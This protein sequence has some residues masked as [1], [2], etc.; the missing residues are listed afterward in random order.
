MGRMGNDDLRFRQFRDEPAYDECLRL[1]L[2]RGLVKTI[3]GDEAEVSLH[4]SVE[5]AD[6][7]DRRVG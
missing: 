1:R 6:P 3:R 4:R 2:E 5:I 7:R